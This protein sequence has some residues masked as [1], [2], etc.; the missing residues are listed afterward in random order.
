MKVFLFLTLLFFSGSLLAFDKTMSGLESELH[1]FVSKQVFFF[2]G[3]DDSTKFEDE[4]Q[5][6]LNGDSPKAM[7]DLYVKVV[8][9]VSA[10]IWEKPSE[11]LVFDKEA[12]VIELLERVSLIED[13]W[14]KDMSVKPKEESNEG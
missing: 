13:F 1:P 7:Y 14:K 5:A 3:K 2:S 12:T 4:R 6:A 8:N 10:T 11:I 9:K